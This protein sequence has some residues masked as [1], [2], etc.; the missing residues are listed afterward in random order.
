MEA[1]LPAAMRRTIAR[2]KIKF[3]NI[4]AVK[5]A[6]EVGLG[7][8]INMIMQTAFFKCANVIPVEEAIRLLKDQIKKMFGIKGD[9][10]VK[11]NWEAVD[12]TL[13]NLVGGL[14]GKL[15]RS[16]GRKTAAPG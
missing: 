9:K 13:A 15:G 5:I 2:K 7:G 4:D 8:R 3:Y 14:S 1:K 16:R 6:T 11:M 12:R 10:I